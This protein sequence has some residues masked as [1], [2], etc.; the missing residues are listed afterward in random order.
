MYSACLYCSHTLGRNEVVEAFPVGRRLAF[1][2]AK[3]RLWVVCPSCQRWCLSPIEERWEAIEACERNFRDARLRASTDEIGLVR[4]KEGLELVRIG[5]PLLPEMSAWRYGRE[6]SARRRRA[7]AYGAGAIGVGAL[8]ATAAVASGAGAALIGLAAFGAPVVHMTALIGFAAYAAVDSARSIRVMHDGKQLRLYRADLGETHLVSTDSGQGWGVRLKHSYAR[9]VLT[10]DEAVRVTA[11]L[12]ARVNGSGAAGHLVDSAVR[13]LV[14]APS[15]ADFM[16]QAAA[17]SSTLAREYTDR[18]KEYLRAF[19]Q[20]AFTAGTFN[21]SANPASLKRI[22]PPVRLAL[23]M[24]LHEESE[25]HALEVELTPLIAA[26][27][28]AEVIAGIADAHPRSRRT[29]RRNWRGCPQPTITLDRPPP[30]RARARHAD[31]HESRLPASRIHARSRAAF[32]PPSLSLS[33]PQAIITARRAAVIVANPTVTPYRGTASSEPSAGNVR[34]LSRRVASLSA[35]M[36]VPLS[37]AVPGGSNATCPS[38]APDA[39]TQ[40]SIPPASAIC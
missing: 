12:L 16:R 23:E 35:T 40:Q 37:I 20:N 34:R 24:A 15:L 14:E 10:G 21:E 36:R 3:G 25:R 6:F 31:T 27:R 39:S 5:A 19:E 33:R 8:G 1:D 18:H 11:R 9:V 7:M 4:L 22:A 26:W 38:L 32:V 17:H 28:D 13:R 29:S 2:A 30:H